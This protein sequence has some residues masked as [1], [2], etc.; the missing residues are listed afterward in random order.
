MPRY[1]L[2]IHVV[3]VARLNDL[4]AACGK[5]GADV[6]PNFSWSVR[7]PVG[8]MGYRVVSSA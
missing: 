7:G 8:G 5:R 3:V 4:I 1:E 2:Y 6:R